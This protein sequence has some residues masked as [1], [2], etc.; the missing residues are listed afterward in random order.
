MK[1]VMGSVAWVLVVD[2]YAGKPR[3]VNT[4]EGNRGAELL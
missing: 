2:E 1:C 4:R 3:Y